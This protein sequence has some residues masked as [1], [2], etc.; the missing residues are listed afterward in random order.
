MS[1]SE[2]RVFSVGNFF[3]FPWIN[4]CDI[5]PLKVP[6]CCTT[7]VLQEK[8]NLLRKQNNPTV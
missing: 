3:R 8:V 7:T 2:L 6:V 4:L 5:I 1:I